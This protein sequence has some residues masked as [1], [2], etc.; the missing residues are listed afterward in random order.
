MGTSETPV[1]ALTSTQAIRNAYGMSMDAANRQAMLDSEALQLIARDIN[2]SVEL[3]TVTDVWSKTNGRVTTVVNLD[4]HLTPPEESLLTLGH[5]GIENHIYPIAMVLKKIQDNNLQA[6]ERKTIDSL[7][8]RIHTLRKT[9]GN[10]IN[11]NTIIMLGVLI[12]TGGMT[13]DISEIFL[14]ESHYDANPEVAQKQKTQVMI[15]AQDYYNK[16]SSLYSPEHLHYNN[17]A[18]HAAREAIWSG[19]LDLENKSTKQVKDEFA[20]AYLGENYGQTDLRAEAYAGFEIALE[21]DVS[22]RT[23]YERRWLGQLEITKDSVHKIVRSR[24]NFEQFAKTKD[25]PDLSRLNTAVDNLIDAAILTERGAKIVRAFVLRMYQVNPF[26]LQGIVLDVDTFKSVEG[27]ATVVDGERQALI[28]Q[29][30]AGDEHRAIIVI[31]HELSHLSTRLHIERGSKE[32]NQWVYLMKNSEEAASWLRKMVISWEGGTLTSKAEDMIDH[33]MSSPHEFIAAM[34]QYFLLNDIASLDLDLT[35]AELRHHQKAIGIVKKVIN[36]A[37]SLFNRVS[38][39]FSNFEQENPNLYRKVNELRLKGMGWDNAG[40][41][42]MREAANPIWSGTVHHRSTKYKK[43]EVA[44]SD[45]EY[46]KIVDAYVELKE[47][48]EEQGEEFTQNAELLKL[49]TMALDS[50]SN[51]MSMF[52]NSRFDKH[53]NRSRFLDRWGHEK[54]RTFIDISKMARETGSNKNDYVLALDYAIDS[55]LGVYGD[56]VSQGAAS[57]G[58][59]IR[60]LVKDK[61]KIDLMDIVVGSSGASLTWAGATVFQTIASVLLEDTVV[62][63]V[64]G[65]S[66]HEGM[67]SIT[68]SLAAFEAVSDRM[69][70]IEM[71]LVEVGVTKDQ[72]PYIRAQILKYAEVGEGIIKIPKEI[73][74]DIRKQVADMAK[75]AGDTMARFLRDLVKRGVDAHLWHKGF[76]SFVPLKLNNVFSGDVDVSTTFKAEMS[77]LIQ[78]RLTDRSEERIDGLSFYVAGLLPDISSHQ[79]MLEELGEM[80]KDSKRKVIGDYLIAEALRKTRGHD[81]VNTLEA[82]G[83]IKHEVEQ[84]WLTMVHEDSK[85]SL[86]LKEALLDSTVGIIKR[87]SKSGLDWNGLLGHLQKHGDVPIVNIKDTYFNKMYSKDTA[88]ISARLSTLNLRGEGIIPDYLYYSSNEGSVGSDTSKDFSSVAQLHYH[89]LVNKASRGLY[90][91][92]NTWVIPNFQHIAENPKITDALIIEPAVLT[93]AFKKSVG[94]QVIETEMMR[95][96]F[97]LHGDYGDLLTVASVAFSA[98]DADSFY[99]PDGTRLSPREHQEVIDGIDTL[100][101]KWDFV[102]GIQRNVR[103]TDHLSQRFADLAPALTKIAFGGNLAMATALVEGVFNAVVSVGGLNTFTNFTRSIFGSLAGLTSDQRKKVARELTHSI[104]AIA[105]GHLDDYSRPSKSVED[106]FLVRKTKEWGDAM[107]IPAKKVIG[108]LAVNRSIAMR[109]T[110]TDYYNS[111]ALEELGLAI[112]EKG[113]DVLNN[114]AVLRGLMR[115]AKI[116]RGDIQLVKLMIQAGLFDYGTLETFLNLMRKFTGTGSVNK[117]S[118]YMLDDFFTY[119]NTELSVD[120]KTGEGYAEYKNIMNMVTQLRAL[121]KNFL[122]QVLISPNAFDVYTGTEGS[123][124]AMQSIYEIFRRYPMLFVNQ[125]VIRAAGNRSPMAWAFQLLSLLFLDFLYMMMLRIAAG[126]EP[127]EILKESKEDPLKFII[128]YGTRLPLLGRWGGAVAEIATA[129]LD[130]RQNAMGVGFIPF[131]AI[132]ATGKGLGT[133]GASL[134]DSLGLTESKTT[135]ED[136]VNAMRM[137]PYLGD[138]FVRTGIHQGARMAG[139]DLGKTKITSLPSKAA[140]EWDDVFSHG[141]SA[142]GHPSQSLAQLIKELEIKPQDWSKGFTGEL[143]GRTAPQTP[144]EQPTLPQPAETE[145]DLDAVTKLMQQKATR[146]PEGLVGG[147]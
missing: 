40:K 87:M 147:S 65:L 24:E 104:E 63:T 84:S 33:Y 98:K 41:N 68:K 9:P 59:T 17:K 70:A 136:L 129:F 72:L 86:A 107:M 102:R 2:P 132:K 119:M 134:S 4:E 23:H 11:R 31:A 142:Y 78:S 108:T 69:G 46:S 83:T 7:I 75:D 64:N 79:K 50:S 61:L 67:P 26:N 85:E 55:L 123:R 10:I 126:N 74:P 6:V 122:N 109:T 62:T 137:I 60:E 13:G 124:G 76:K 38:S 58:N 106:H 91:P 44:L 14:N 20:K 121:E 51:T 133:M 48:S 53:A 144:I 118:Y 95:E 36:Y 88:A 49:Q 145:H 47:Q 110:I 101:G 131:D 116:K 71:A 82:D 146:A 125:K 135:T 138:S 27:A 3:D 117:T 16:L 96:N 54:D 25:S 93:K 130:G 30:L 35:P 56:P 15:L 105:K 92:N 100:R 12:D 1:R 28:S 81:V 97:G 139:L 45:E 143:L 112:R 29:E 99:H 57:V 8:A 140:Q 141:P 34:S 39:V 94:D 66:R 19:Q 111:G 127:E 90:F 113:A 32:Y 52:G 89:N 18:I 21:A 103:M 37:M 114:D 43:K 128:M 73:S 5:T 80:R 22:E 77:R 42:I 115:K 120:N